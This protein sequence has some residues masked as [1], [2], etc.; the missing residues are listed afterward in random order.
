MGRLLI[1][2]AERTN[3][4]EC[5]YFLYTL[6]V[7][8]DLVTRSALLAKPKN[9]PNI[10]EMNQDENVL[11]EELLRTYVFLRGW[12]PDIPLEGAFTRDLSLD[13]GFSSPD[14][15]TEV[16]KC[17]EVVTRMRGEDDDA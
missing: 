14:V 12:T 8:R 1:V 17:L 7:I 16:E 9:P 15:D 6:L 11:S 5:R 13:L 10:Y 2:E 3:R 4:A